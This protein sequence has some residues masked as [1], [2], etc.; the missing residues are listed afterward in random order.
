MQRL[1]TLHFSFIIIKLPVYSLS[2]NA[3][4]KKPATTAPAIGATQNNQD[5]VKYPPPAKIA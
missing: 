5:W 3:L 4:C 2:K 1:I